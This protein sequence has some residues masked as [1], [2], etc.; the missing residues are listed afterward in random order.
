MDDVEGLRIF[1]RAD[2]D[3]TSTGEVVDD[4]EGLRIFVD[5]AAKVPSSKEL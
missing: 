4:V 1:S 2:K 5:N 3:D